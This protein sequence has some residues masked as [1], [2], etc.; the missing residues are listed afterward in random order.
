MKIGKKIMVG[1]ICLVEYNIRMQ[2]LPYQRKIIPLVERPVLEILRRIRVSQPPACMRDT[3]PISC[4]NPDFALLQKKKSLLLHRSKNGLIKNKRTNTS[5]TWNSP[6][7]SP[8]TETSP[9]T[10]DLHS[11]LTAILALVC[12]TTGDVDAILQ[13]RHPCR[14][15]ACP[16]LAAS[17]TST[18]CMAD[19]SL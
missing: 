6:E 2:K 9:G 12:S 4:Q 8:E 17:P 7:T 1:I 10:G 18:G 13:Y 14:Q 11:S 15:H 19:R 5:P 16:S 3:C